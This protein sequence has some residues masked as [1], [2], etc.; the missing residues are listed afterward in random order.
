M[1]DHSS[2]RATASA[3]LQKHG[4]P[5]TLSLKSTSPG[6]A[7]PWEPNANVEVNL[8]IVIMF[9]PTTLRDDKGTV[10]P[11][12]FQRAYFASSDAE[13][14]W[15]EWYATNAPSVD[16]VPEFPKLTTKDTIVDDGRVYQ[17]VR[18]NEVKPGEQSILFDITI[19][20]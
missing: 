2:F 16:P 17:F 13:E 15:A 20:G 8:N 1:S 7:K 14:A 19:A 3:L 5:S 4:R 10:I 9:F 11:G 6:A 12:N 18:M